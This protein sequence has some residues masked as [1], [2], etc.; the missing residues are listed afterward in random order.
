MADKP[1][2]YWRLNEQSLDDV[3]VDES[4][5]CRHG[6]IVGTPTLSIE[7]AIQGNSN[8]SIKFIPKSYIE[9]PSSPDFSISTSGDGLT[10]EVWMR[11]DQ[12]EFT[13]EPGSQYVHWLG[14][15]EPNER[16]WGFRFYTKHDP[17]FPNRICAYAWN[18]AGDE[19]AGDDYREPIK[20]PS[21][22]LHFVAC[23]EPYDENQARSRGVILYT[24]GTTGKGYRT[25]TTFYENPGRWHVIPKNG[26]SPLQLATRNRTGFLSGGLDEVAIYPKVLSPEQIS[27]HYAA[28]MGR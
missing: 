2:G 19:G 1:V 13:P 3:V 10:V 12:T 14:K 17:N 5:H 26:D 4:G 25:K 6:K 23:F 21:P 24:N 27:S 15:G 28:G 16:E 8:K 20:I 7:G 9:I 18:L 11:P 22:W